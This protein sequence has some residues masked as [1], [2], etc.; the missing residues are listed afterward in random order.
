MESTGLI[1]FGAHTAHHE[2]VRNLD[3]AS[4]RDELQSSVEE[5]CEP[6]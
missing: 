4:L 3:D 2:I 6:L 5:V 1:S